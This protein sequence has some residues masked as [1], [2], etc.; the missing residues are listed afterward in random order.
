MPVPMGPQQMASGGGQPQGNVAQNTQVSPGQESIGNIDQVLEALKAG[1]QQ[2][3]DQNGFV[4]INKLVQVWPQ[5]AQQMGIDI[6]LQTILQYIQS[7]PEMLVGMVQELGLSGVIVDDKQIG[8]DQLG[9]GGGENAE[10]MQTGAA[11]MAGGAE[12][13]RGGV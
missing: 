1:I 9:G 11:P 3:V 10:P 5:I 4:D 8:I 7:H 12:M 13:A 2:A 6:P